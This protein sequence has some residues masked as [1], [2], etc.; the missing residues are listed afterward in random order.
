MLEQQH[1][2]ELADERAEPGTAILVLGSIL[3]WHD[4]FWSIEWSERPFLF[5]RLALVLA[6]GPAGEYNPES[7]H[8]YPDPAT[9]L[10][11]EFLS[12]QGIGAVV[13]FDE[14]SM[15]RAARRRWS[16][17]RPGTYSVFLVRDT[18]PDHYGRRRR[19]D[20]DRPG[21]SALRRDGFATIDDVRGST[22]LVPRWTATG[23][24]PTGRGSRKTQTDS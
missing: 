21:E 24:R 5:R 2:V 1:A 19:D 20:R 7:E 4:Q 8:V 14:R 17:F 3:S 23:R 13:V 15:R 16:R 10:D 22:Q 9:T 6:E 18:D 12:G 11:P